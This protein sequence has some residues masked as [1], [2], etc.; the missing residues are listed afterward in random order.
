MF[1]QLH[2]MPGAKKRNRLIILKS[3]VVSQSWVDLFARV[4]VCLILSEQI[5]NQRQLFNL[6][7]GRIL[8]GHNFQIFD[9]WGRTNFLRIVSCLWLGLG[10][11]PWGSTPLLWAARAGR[12]SVVERLLEAKAVVNAKTRSG[13]SLGGRLGGKS[14]ETWDCCEVKEMLMVHDGSSVLWIL[15]SLFKESVPVCQNICTNNFCCSLS[16]RLCRCLHID[17]LFGN[18]MKLGHLRRTLLLSW[19]MFE[20]FWAYPCQFD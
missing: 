11:P 15:L 16:S 17:L 2:E 18:R 4:G 1:G 13:H 14:H 20:L 12:D 5:L 19:S 7:S 9:F 8:G 6:S 3:W 10:P